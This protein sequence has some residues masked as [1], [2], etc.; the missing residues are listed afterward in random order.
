MVFFQDNGIRV[1]KGEVEDSQDGS[2]D[3]SSRRKPAAALEGK[4][5]YVVVLLLI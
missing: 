4:D 5:I 3:G 2:I 1:E